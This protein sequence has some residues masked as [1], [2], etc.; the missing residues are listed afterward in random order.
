MQES[1]SSRTLGRCPYLE[2]RF[3]VMVAM[4]PVY[5]ASVCQDNSST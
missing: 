3:S 5:K 4:G 2:P 1:L